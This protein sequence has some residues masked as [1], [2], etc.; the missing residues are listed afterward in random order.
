MHA[1]IILQARMAS[2]RLPGKALEPIAG[3]SLIVRC[4]QRLGAAGVGPVILATTTG[5]ED[6]ALVSAGGLYADLFSLQ[7]AGY[8]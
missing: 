3:R 5:S 4:L 2:Q 7:A 8:R 1:G 6:D